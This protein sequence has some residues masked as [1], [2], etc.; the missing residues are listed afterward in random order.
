MKE[1][2][3]YIH[4]TE[5]SEQDRLAALN[6]LTN[7]AYLDF[8]EID[9][10][11]NI[12]ELGSGLGIIANEVASR[13]QNGSITG[14]E[15]SK[16]QIAKNKSHPKLKIQQG[17]VHEMPFE[18][19]QFDL[20][21][22]RY[23]IEHLR[24]PQKALNEAFRVLKSGGQIFLQENTISLMRLYPTCVNFDKVWGQFNT[25]Q[26]DTGGDGDIGIKLYALAKKAGFKDI[27]LEMA[28]EIHHV[29]TGT[30][31]AW[32]DNLIGNIIGAQKLLIEKELATK[33]EIKAAAEELEALKKDEFASAYFYWNR[34]KAEK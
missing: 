33:E 4:G 13:M 11:S 17:D 9:P 27:K 16:E 23:I 3:L 21:H 1:D 30:L 26:E 7:V 10:D 20:I 32:V 5:S 31:D 8:I 34:L 22:G 28:P 29:E 6:D 15:Y 24:D 19:Q 14:I 2:N 18:D 12:L 25:L